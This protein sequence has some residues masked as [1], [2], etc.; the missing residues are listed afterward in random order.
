MRERDNRRRYPLRH[1]ARL[2]LPEMLKRAK[3]GLDSFAKAIADVKKGG[4]R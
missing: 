4:D 3:Y 1:D 2:L